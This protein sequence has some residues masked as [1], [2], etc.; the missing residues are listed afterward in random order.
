[1]T[2]CGY[3]APGSTAA[4]F[5]KLTPLVLTQALELAGTVVCEPKL[6][7]VLEIPTD[8]IGSV[9]AALAR[10]GADVETPSLTGELALVQTVLSAARTREVQRQLS[11]LTRGEG[12][13]A[14]SFEGYEPVIGEPPTR[15]RTTPNPLNLDEYMAHLAG[16]AAAGAGSSDAA[17]RER[18]R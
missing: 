8:T 16:H 4:D 13:L 6:R 18:L 17:T 14:S 12:V 5:R 15:R 10:L 2:D 7:V 11:G 3:R 9:M 1:M